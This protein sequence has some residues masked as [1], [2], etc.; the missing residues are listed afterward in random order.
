[1]ALSLPKAANCL[2]KQTKVL[3]R[4]SVSTTRPYV[5]IPRA[6]FA[7][8]AAESSSLPLSGIKVLDMSRVLAGVRSSPFD[9]PYQ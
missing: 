6:R 9:S 3:S 8:A 7:T 2:V 4:I 1:M 5:Y